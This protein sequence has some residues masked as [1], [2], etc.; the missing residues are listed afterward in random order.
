[1]AQEGK[2]MRVD[3]RED[4]PHRP[5]KLVLLA[6]GNKYEVNSNTFFV[7]GTARYTSIAQSRD[8]YL[9]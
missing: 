2:R 3:G 4:F 5:V 8:S 6:N 9:I 1:M 7:S